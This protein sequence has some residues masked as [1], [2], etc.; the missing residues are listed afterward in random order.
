MEAMSIEKEFSQTITKYKDSMIGT[1]I[2]LM[3]QKKYGNEWDNIQMILNLISD[4]KE[5]YP[6]M[7]DALYEH[8]RDKVSK[9]LNDDGTGTPECDNW[10]EIL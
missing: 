8:C 4:I 7:Y 10:K 6:A 1:F 3:C 2:S 9:F 5:K